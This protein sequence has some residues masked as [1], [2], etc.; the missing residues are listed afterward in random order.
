MDEPEKRKKHKEYKE[1]FVRWQ[2]VL[3]EH[4]TFSNN[5]LLT[6]AIGTIGYLITFL[7]NRE[8]NPQCAQKLFFSFGFC[9][10]SISLISG[11]GTIITRSIDFRTTVKKIK[12]KM[13]MDE[14]NSTEYTTI[15]NLYGN[16]T[17]ILFYCQCISFM[18]GALS[19]LVSFIRH[20]FE[21]LF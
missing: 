14:C 19:I 21:K 7:N 12:T 1:R 20:N 13:I 3:R 11:F 8:F 4:L 9:L 16:L 6:V 10:I 15:M 5:L 17:W 2:T 18:I